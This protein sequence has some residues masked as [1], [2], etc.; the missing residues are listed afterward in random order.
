MDCTLR[1]GGT[2]QEL[3]LTPGQRVEFLPQSIKSA[4]TA[5]EFFK[6]ALNI[7]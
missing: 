3:K 6:S 2:T 4:N 7:N 1:Y 5:G